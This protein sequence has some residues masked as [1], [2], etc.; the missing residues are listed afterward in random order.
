MNTTTNILLLFYVKM[1]NEK[2]FINKSVLDE[3]EYIIVTVKYKIIYIFHYN[4]EGSKKIAKDIEEKGNK[5][6]LMMF[7]NQSS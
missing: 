6:I 3:E 5:I 4:I 2:I 1:S 7:E